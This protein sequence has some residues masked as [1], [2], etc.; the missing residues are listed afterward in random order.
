MVSII[1]TPPNN[2][3][4]VRAS[5]FLRWIISFL[6]TSALVSSSGIDTGSVDYKAALMSIVIEKICV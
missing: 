5:F 1:L 6:V 3:I 4:A 2:S